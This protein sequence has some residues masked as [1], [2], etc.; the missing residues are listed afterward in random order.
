MEE[1]Q[2]ET[3][4]QTTSVLSS[5][6]NNRKHSSVVVLLDVRRTLH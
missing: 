2:E 5:C 3:Q 6:K 4:Y 1:L